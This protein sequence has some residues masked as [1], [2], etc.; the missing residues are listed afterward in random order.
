MTFFCGRNEHKPI[1]P[2]VNIGQLVNKLLSQQPLP[3]LYCYH[4]LTFH[5]LQTGITL[6]FPETAEASAGM[7]N[8]GKAAHSGGCC[9]I[10]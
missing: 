10:T 9:N 1:T 5:F 4:P 8:D 3:G 6:G 7:Q 2:G